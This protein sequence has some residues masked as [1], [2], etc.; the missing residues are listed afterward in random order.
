MAFSTPLTRSR[1]KMERGNNFNV[2][3][4]Y[5]SFMDKITRTE[6]YIINKTDLILK[7]NNSNKIVNLRNNNTLSLFSYLNIN[8]KKFNTFAPHAS[9]K[10][11]PG[12]LE[13]GRIAGKTVLSKEE[14]LTDIFIKGL[15]IIKD[16][17]KSILDCPDFYLEKERVAFRKKLSKV[18]G[19]YMIKCKLDNRLFFIGQAVDLSIRLGSHFSRSALVSSKLGTSLNFIGWNNLSVHLLEICSVPTGRLPAAYRPPTGR[20]PAA[21]R[22]PTGRL[23][24]AYRP[25]TGRGITCERGSF[26]KG[27]LTHTKWKIY[28]NLF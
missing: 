5:D 27:G 7:F 20:L 18:S 10:D 15:K 8:R 9:F 21:Y 22:P 11:L 12:S 1:D 3:K 17:P 19:I 26:Y 28:F 13:S 24:A 23:P 25:P 14:Y 4:V 2:E 16:C 6:P